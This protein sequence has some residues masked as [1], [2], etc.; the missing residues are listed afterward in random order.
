LPA[1][2]VAAVLACV[3]SIAL[4]TIP[5]PTAPSTK[6]AVLGHG[7]QSR[8]ATRLPDSL[9]TAASASIG[10]SER[11]FWPIRRGSLL[12]AQG[13]G[14]HS[15]FTVSGVE[16]R[17]AQGT[18]GLSLVGV[19][20]GQSLDSVAGAAPTSAANTVLYKHDS[21]A[22]S[23]RNG[24]YGLEQG[25]V[26]QHRPQGGKGLLVLALN[27]GGSLVPEQ[28]G[29]QI[30]LRTHAGTTALGY[31]ELH[32]ADASGRAL[33][34][35]MQLLRGSVRLVVDDSR[36]RYP[37]RIDPFVQQGSE[38]TG[39]GPLCGYHLDALSGDGN[40]AL[41]GNLCANGRAG[42]AWVFTR[43]GSTWSQQA[44][45]V[46]TDRV[47]A[48]E[49]GEDVA[50]SADG[51]TALVGG[52][53]DNSGRGAAWVFTRSGSTWTQ[54]GPKFAG[55]ALEKCGVSV[56]LSSD[57]NTALMGC[58]GGT[59]S[60]YFFTRSSSTWTQQGPRVAVSAGIAAALSGD[61]NTAL[62]TGSGATLL[63]RAGST[64]SQQGPSLSVP[65]SGRGGASL[66]ADGNTGLA[67]GSVIVRSGTSWT[68]QQHL[69]TSHQGEALSA[70]GNLALLGA[71][72]GPVLFARSG[73]T[74][75]QKEK[76]TGESG[77]FVSLSESGHT[78][79]SGDESGWRVFVTPAPVVV[80][81]TA[82]SVTQ[83]SATLNA[84][85]NPEGQ[86]VSDC[87][88]EYGLT[89]SYGT[90]VAC[91]SL[92]GGGES[93]VAVSASIVGGLSA[94]TTYH[95]RIVATNPTGT[96]ESADRTFTTLPSAPVVLTEPA[97]AVTSASATLNATVNPE[98]GTVSECEF[99]Y[100]P[101]TGY[102]SV[103][104]CSALPGSGETPVA[105]SASVTGLNPS[106]EY[107]FR[108]LA[109]N[110][111]GTSHGGDQTFTTLPSPPTV[112]TEPA[113]SVTQTSATLNATVNPNGGTVSDCHFEYGTSLPYASSVPCSSLPG[114]G[115]SAVP[116]SAGVAGLTANTTYHFRIV[117]T[118]PGGSSHGNDKTFTTLNSPEFGR[119]IKVTSGAGKYE[120][121]GCTKL[122]GTKSYEWVPGLVKH[123]FATKI[124]GTTTVTLE[125]TKASKVTCKTE[126]GTGEYTGLK[127]VGG[128]VL[129]FTGCERLG[130]KCSTAGAAEGEVVTKPLEGILGVT[131]R[132]ATSI[133]DKVGLDLFPVGKLGSVMEFSCGATSLTVQDSVI[134]PVATNS[135]RLTS[136]LA[137]AQS[138][139]KQKPEK[140][141][142]E[143]RDVLEVS[144][145][146][147]AF[148][149][150]GLALTT[151]QT[152]E[153][154]VEINSVV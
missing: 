50:L 8:P 37:V 48:A 70:D 12:L 79:L 39:L 109:K 105:V 139:G 16:L 26:V 143:T 66:S 149:Q 23:Y 6:R 154:K 13:G 101:G 74:W 30:L 146:G 102:G 137:F 72:G 78:A 98:G 111:G 43:S 145:N 54:Q 92:P 90:S 132:G 49:F 31:R 93:A 59:G 5:S 73:S 3:A 91:S 110:A 130:E 1:L 75:T 60:V 112:A 77:A 69:T 115:N 52:E 67:G 14:I 100:G 113:S 120:N 68:V 122:G 61:G 34:A 138:G 51:N 71:T 82:S 148:E 96:S 140:F 21:V 141:V 136:T 24:P 152:N 129:T 135:M 40:T 94:N 80:T 56:G 121:A 57:G 55:G 46:P 108:I 10:A 86:T 116:V 9:A 106:T 2:A 133:Q 144:F 42:A 18:L 7:L 119:C 104:A 147:A 11:R 88:F 124:S 20:R 84:T 99:E 131:A 128:V 76:L 53:H 41:L 83:T 47:G 117:A 134:V 33:P 28:V 103:V 127:T 22:E 114:S 153:E 27:L 29:S 64:W 126:T 65:G 62:V 32:A 58:H 19:G 151:I 63:V 81:G 35:H 45:L 4:A 38:I 142:G 95:F 89:V 15:T 17:V 123:H 25:F 107:H 36:A 87:H 44:E 150:I 97:S 85:V 125:T 118:N